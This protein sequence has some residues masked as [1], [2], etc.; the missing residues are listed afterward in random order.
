MFLDFANTV[1]SLSFTSSGVGQTQVQLRGITSGYNVSPTVGIYVDDVP[2]GSSTP[3]VNGAQLALDVGLFDLSRIEILRGPQGTLYG[4]STM[5]GLLK[6]VA[7][8]PDTSTFGG[9]ARAN[10]SSTQHHGV[11]YNASS[12]INVPLVEGTSALRV[13]GFYLHNGGYVDNL[14][15][16]DEDVD[17]ADV[18]GGRIDFLYAPNERLSVR[19]ATFAQDVE[20][21]GSIAADFDRTGGDPIDGELEQRRALAEPFDQ[22]FRLASATVKYS[23]D[24]AALTSITSYQTATSEAISD[25]S[26]LYVPQLG[27]PS[28]FSAIGLTRNTDTDKFTQEVRL[29]D[30]GPVVDWLLGGFLPA[31]TANSSSN[32]SPTIRMARSRPSIFSL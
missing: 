17:Q 30:A 4:A 7:N 2:Y 16:H 12:A 21:G 15:L 31:R 6:Y 29:A 11:G 24:S 9:T 1:P 25:F 32:C 13:G 19:L 26:A 23:F 27:G 5:G 3:F 14:T 22:R 8:V 10:I 28:V 18:Y 20:R